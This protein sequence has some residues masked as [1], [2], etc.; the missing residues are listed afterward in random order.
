MCSA[1]PV[2]SSDVCPVWGCQGVA[3]V[4]K[5]VSRGLVTSASPGMHAGLCGLSFE[6]RQTCSDIVW[7]LGR[8][9]SMYKVCCSSVCIGNLASDSIWE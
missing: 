8:F 3:M 7:D 9:N 2:A 6:G 1:R 4:V 5:G